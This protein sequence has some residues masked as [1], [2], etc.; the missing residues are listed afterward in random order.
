MIAYRHDDVSAVA[1]PTCR[2][3]SGAVRHC[4]TCVVLAGILALTA[5]AGTGP[6]ADPA[7]PI[8]GTPRP[9]TPQDW[10]NLSIVPARPDNL[11]SPAERYQILREMEQDRDTL[12]GDATTP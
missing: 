2:P 8:L 5:C 9:P 7:A 3:R 4:L 1:D 11:P 12:R 6:E 10:P